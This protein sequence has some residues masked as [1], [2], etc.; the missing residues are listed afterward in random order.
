MGKLQLEQIKNQLAQTLLIVDEKE[1]PNLYY[2]VSIAL[3]SARRE[4]EK[5]ERKEIK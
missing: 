4:L 3:L 2:Q 5:T 1:W